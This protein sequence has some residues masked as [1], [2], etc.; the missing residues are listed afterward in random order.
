MHN[1]DL[2]SGGIGDIQV[3]LITLSW[4]IT[5]GERCV[6]LDGRGD[7]GGARVA[8]QVDEVRDGLDPLVIGKVAFLDLPRRARVRRV[9]PGI[10]AEFTRIN[11]VF[12]VQRVGR[13]NRKNRVGCVDGKYRSP[14]CCETDRQLIANIDPCRLQCWRVLGVV[15][16]GIQAGRID[17]Y[18]GDCV[19]VVRPFIVYSE[20]DAVT[21]HLRAEPAGRVGNLNIRHQVVQW[22]RVCGGRVNH[23]FG[24]VGIGACRGTGCDCK[25]NN[26]GI[27]TGRGAYS[28][29]DVYTANVFPVG[30]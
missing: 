29:V 15:E 28:F 20:L 4:R 16:V 21:H 26:K 23:H 19:V 27:D 3:V 24:E 12:E 18:G 9:K 2:G 10:R 30:R 6:T 13:K 1:R 8:R 14:N 7:I 22:I 25:R 11:R 17:V 5:V